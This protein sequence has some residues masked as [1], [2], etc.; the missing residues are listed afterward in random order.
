VAIGLRDRKRW[1]ALMRVL[2]AYLD[3]DRLSKYFTLLRDGDDTLT[4]YVLAIADEA[5]WKIPDELRAKME[6]ALTGFVEGRVVR[7]SALPTAD[8]TIRKVAAL[9]ALARGKEP[10]KPAL[11]DSIAIEPNLWPT[12]AVIDWYLLQKRQPALPRSA[13]RRQEAMQILRSRLN[14]QG[15]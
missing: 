3:R 12:S 11:L 14:F 2:P 13:A 4:V 6:Q 7:Y 8:L 9:A 5:G 15:T 10:I 1:Y